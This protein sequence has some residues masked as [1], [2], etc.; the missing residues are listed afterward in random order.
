[1]GSVIR[2]V[3]L[4]A[5]LA[6]TVISYPTGSSSSGDQPTEMLAPVDEN[7]SCNAPE[8]GSAYEDAVNSLNKGLILLKSYSHT[9]NYHTFVS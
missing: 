2:V 9:V 8:D 1:M 3:F 7:S 4:L 6:S 5:C